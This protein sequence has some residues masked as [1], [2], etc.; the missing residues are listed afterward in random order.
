MTAR[1][2]R[3]ALVAFLVARGAS[4]QDAPPASDSWFVRAGVSTARVLAASPFAEGG[5]DARSLSLEVGRQTGGTR[6]WHRAYNDPSYGVGVYLGRFGHDREL[7]R[8]VAT[9]G[10]FSWPFPVARRA[11][12]TADVGLGVS[13]NW[14]AYDRVTN[15]T[16][17]AFGSTVAYHVDGGVSLRV[18][19]GGRS[20]I[21]AGMDFA[22]WS[23]GATSQPNLGLAIV[24]PKLGV[25]YDFTH[26]V[27]PARPAP[28][29]L[30]RFEPAWE[31]VV[32]AAGSGKTTVA[33]T[34]SHID[35]VDL[36]RG[37][38]AFNVT[39]AVQRQFYRYGKVAAGADASY[40]GATGAH[41][42]IVNGTQSETR[43]PTGDRFALG[44]YGGYE[45]VMAR[46]SVLA[47]AGY[48]VWRGFD[49][50]E[51]PRFYQRYGSRVY[52]SE[53][54]WATFAVRTIKVRKAN[55]LEF[56][57]GYRFRR[58]SVSGRT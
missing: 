34:G 2:G 28:G 38:N 22:H 40:D 9:Y 44:A 53:R 31:F 50:P 56:G 48:T 43:A 27:T 33:A 23:N 58:P 51:V 12:V 54:F 10:F 37:F 5:D 3:L 25:R 13:W 18:L 55:F 26:P 35:A 41:V 15:P 19:T 29:E 16:N 52:F 7:G 14:R 4:A 39:T 11:Q 1:A 21:Y 49:D 30:T 6:E 17:T 46:F 45:H 36:W 20:S 24:G 42:D 57:V 47:Q 8:P 32:G